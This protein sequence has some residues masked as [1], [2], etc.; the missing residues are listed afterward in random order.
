LAQE[1]QKSNDFRDFF[2]DII[3][4][5]MSFILWISRHPAL[6]VAQPG[7]SYPQTGRAS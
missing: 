1:R 7:P 4:M 2:V 3:R 5:L 6:K